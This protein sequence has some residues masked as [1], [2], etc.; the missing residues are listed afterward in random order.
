[1][2]FNRWEFEFSKDPTQFYNF[3]SAKQQSSALPL[4]VRL[5]SFEV[6]TDP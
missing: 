3:F 4:S 6:S 5:N 1:M 2:Y